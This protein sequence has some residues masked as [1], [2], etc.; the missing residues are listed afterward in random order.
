MQPTGQM[1]NT[2]PN[3]QVPQ[4]PNVASLVPDPTQQASQAKA[5]LGFVNT[6]QDHLMQYKGGQKKAQE[7]SMNDKK[8]QDKQQE[9]KQVD[10]KSELESFKG[11]IEKMINEKIGGIKDD[12]SKA[13]SEEDGKK[14]N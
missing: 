9:T 3:T 5:N 2:K 8:Q 13:L 4:D 7:K 11:D 1:I 6:M 14:Q 10:I 12:I